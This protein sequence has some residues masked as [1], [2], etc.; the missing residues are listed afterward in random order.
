MISTI[1]L[2]IICALAIGF[3]LVCLFGFYAAAKERPMNGMLLLLPGQAKQPLLEPRL[4]EIR[5]S[6][7]CPASKTGAIVLQFPPS[8]GWA[9]RQ[10]S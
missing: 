6:P 2:T 3:F 9:M 8:A 7:P 10:I 5:I 1:V 4:G